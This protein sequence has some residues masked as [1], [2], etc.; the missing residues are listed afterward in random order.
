MDA[1]LPMLGGA[2]LGAL[3]SIWI[4]W[5]SVRYFQFEAVKADILAG[6][7]SYVNELSPLTIKRIHLVEYWF[8]LH[9]WFRKKFHPSYR[10]ILMD[11]YD[12]FSKIK[13]IEERIRRE[14]EAIEEKVN[15][16]FIVYR[17][18]ISGQILCSANNAICGYFQRHQRDHLMAVRSISPR[19]RSILFPPLFLGRRIRAEQK[20]RTHDFEM[21]ED[22]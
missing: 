16:E 17:G 20:R 8:E 9:N 7:S 11:Q 4:T 6:L 22:Q 2:V 3:C 15:Q 18:A 21:R 19:W 5:A 10:L 13:S 14:I 1:F 12:A